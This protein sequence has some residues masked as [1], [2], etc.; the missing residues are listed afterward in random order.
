[1]GEGKR[2]ALGRLEDELVCS[3]EISHRSNNLCKQLARETGAE[4]VMG[5][6]PVGT[7]LDQEDLAMCNFVPLFKPNVNG[8][9]DGFKRMFLYL[10]ICSSSPMNLH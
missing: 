7:L 8:S 1:M 4:P 6:P 3:E 5:Q 9:K 2:E 10:F